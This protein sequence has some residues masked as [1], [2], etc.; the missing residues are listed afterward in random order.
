M[1]PPARSSKH[2]PTEQ[3]AK[4]AVTRRREVVDVPTVHA[5]DPR[6]SA[7]SGEV[8][9]RRVERDYAFLNEYRQSEM[10]E[11]RAEIRRTKDKRERERLER[12]LTGMEDRER[13]RKR[14]EERRAVVREHRKCEREKVKAGKTPYFL[15]R[16]EVRR[17]AMERH[18]EGMGA[19]RRAK[20]VERQRKREVGKEK[21]ELPRV[22]RSAVQAGAEG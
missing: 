13:A 21:K 17:Q 11:L 18:L 20:A 6:F 14:D 8:E 15:K 22:R 19:R 3:T 12:Q 9:P 5:R 7:L 16:G 4:R 1:R 10:A 2:A